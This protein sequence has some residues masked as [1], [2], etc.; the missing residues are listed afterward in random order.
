MKAQIFILFFMT[1]T[2]LNFAYANELDLQSRLTEK[3]VAEKLTVLSAACSETA[4]YHAGKKS[5][6]NGGMNTYQLENT[7]QALN[8][9]IKNEAKN[10]VFEKLLDACYAEAQYLEPKRPAGPKERPYVVTKSRKAEYEK[11]INEI[12]DSYKE[13]QSPS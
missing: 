3:D 12:C 8:N 1:V 9:S 7:C 10:E 5:V 2:S 11:H 13:L 4:E 6:K